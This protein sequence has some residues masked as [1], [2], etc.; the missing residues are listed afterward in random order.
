MCLTVVFL[1]APFLCSEAPARDL[2][3]RGQVWEIRETDLLAHLRAKAAAWGAAGAGSAAGGLAAYRRDAER[4]VRAYAESPPAVAGIA[5]A[6]RARSR[7]FDPSIT[8]RNDI[9]DHEGRVIAHAGTTV[10][11]LDYLPLETVLLFI[12]G[13][14]DAQVAWALAR[15]GRTKIVLTKGPVLALM[16]AHGKPFYFDQ[17]GLLTGRFAIA[18][19]PATVTREGR[20][21]RIREFPLSGETKQ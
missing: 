7:L 12:D 3:V 13:T 18:S 15:P 17:K 20:A 19:V 6:T 4:R 10:N 5:R 2:G 14:D 1:A 8:V 21:L 11:P 9:L 16:R